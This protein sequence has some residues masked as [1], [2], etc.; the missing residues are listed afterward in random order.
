MGRPREGKV[1]GILLVLPESVHGGGVGDPQ[2]VSR[3][4]EIAVPLGLVDIERHRTA[5]PAG[6]ALKLGVEEKIDSESELKHRS[7]EKR[8]LSEVVVA[9][10]A[11]DLQRLPLRQPVQDLHRHFRSAYAGQGYFRHNV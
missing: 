1:N 5:A 9:G 11:M 4:P 7:L 6:G 8:V 2:T 3:A 10:P